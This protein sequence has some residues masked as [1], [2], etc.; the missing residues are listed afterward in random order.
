M[1]QSASEPG[2]PEASAAPAEGAG[3]HALRQENAR[4]RARLEELDFLAGMIE[5][6]EKGASLEELQAEIVRHLADH[7]GAE[8]ASLMILDPASGELRVKASRGLAADVVRDARVKLGQDISGRVA[9]TGRGLVI[10][11]VEKTLGRPNRGG[12][13]TPGCMS[14]PLKFRGRIVGVLNFADRR[15]GEF[16]SEDLE[17]ITRLGRQA[18]GLL[19]SAVSNEVLIRQ[20]RYERELQFAHTLQQAFLPGR[21]PEI[22]GLSL[23]ARYVPALEVGGDFYDFIALPEASIGVLIG[24]VAGKGVPAA[25]FMARFSSTF[26]SLAAGGLG[27]GQAMCRANAGVCERSRRGLFV[28]A[29]YLVIDAADGGVQWAN[30][31][32]PV[33]LLRTVDGEVRGLAGGIDVPLGLVAEASYAEARVVL[34]PGETLLLMTDGAFDARGADGGRYGVDRLQEVIGAGPANPRELVEHL[35]KD[36]TR[37]VGSGA[38]AD[39]LTIVAVGRE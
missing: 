20:E 28:T 5:R 13:R 19:L 26:R 34:R 14:A 10:A 15:E 21:P 25:M 3:F 8:V 30:A 35:L 27:A 7:L 24:D 38:R 16:R 33:P 39:D 9:A 37:F 32:H 11:D 23:A 22:E 2:K 17:T 36:I 29:A 31:G 1:N 18:A 6:L 12:Y 4:L